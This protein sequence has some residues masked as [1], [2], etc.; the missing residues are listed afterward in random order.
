MTISKPP[1]NHDDP[2]LQAAPTPSTQGARWRARTEYADRVAGLRQTVLVVD[3]DGDSRLLLSE[4]LRVQCHVIEAS[5]G[6]EALAIAAREPR[7]DLILLDVMMPGMNGYEVLQALRSEPAL[8]SVPVIAVS[9][10]A[11]PHDVARGL[12]AGFAAYIAKPIRFGELLQ[13]LDEIAARA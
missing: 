8:S 6:I 11:M 12:G 2:S 13:R 4:L 3:D 10:D 7:I 1:R 9:A 5:N